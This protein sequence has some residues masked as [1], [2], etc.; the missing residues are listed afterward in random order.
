MKTKIKSLVKM[1]YLTSLSHILF[2]SV[3]FL[4]FYLPCCLC[5]VYKSLGTLT[6]DTVTDYIARN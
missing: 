1:Q 2:H 4:L 3:S 5:F 6:A